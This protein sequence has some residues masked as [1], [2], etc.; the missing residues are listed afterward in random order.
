MRKQVSL[1]RS[2]DFRNTF[3]SGKR[4]LSPRFVLYM[5]TNSSP[6]TRLGVSISKSHFKQATRRNRLRRVARECVRSEVSPRLKGYDIVIAS[7]APSAGADI[8]KAST[9][10]KS[11][12][13]KIAKK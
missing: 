11:L 1:K 12:I 6:E 8:E 9:E 2:S 10:L 4:F 3:K 5:S 7:R 13:S